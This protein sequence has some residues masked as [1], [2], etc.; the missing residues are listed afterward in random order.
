MLSKVIKGCIGAIIL[1]MAAIWFSW[2]FTE[3]NSA[4]LGVRAVKL[5]YQFYDLNELDKNMTD[6]KKIVSNSVYEELT[7]DNE[8]R[9]LTTYLKLKGNTCIV[10]VVESTA[11]YVIYTLETDTIE[12]D[13]KFIFMFSTEGGKIIKV[14]EAECI[15]FTSS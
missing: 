7:I 5:L 14:K 12:N 8:E 4:R 3:R 6:F 10:H 11:D 13:R 9:L 1:T 2:F 15:D